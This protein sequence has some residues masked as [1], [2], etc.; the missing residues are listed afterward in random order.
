MTATY[1]FSDRPA[2]VLPRALWGS[3]RS[4][5]R[6]NSFF[7]FFHLGWVALF[8]GGVALVGVSPGP[9]ALWV[10]LAAAF[11][12]PA[13]VRLGW[14]PGPTALWLSLVAAAAAGATALDGDLTRTGW[15]AGGLVF[16]AV[17]A[18][19]VFLTVT[20][21]PLVVLASLESVRKNQEVYYFWVLLLGGVLTLCFCASH[22][23]V[24]YVLF[25]V[26][27]FPMFLLVGQY[28]PRPQRV[29]A[30]YKF[31][32]YTFGGSAFVLP[33]LVYLQFWCGTT[34]V[35]FLA[36]HQFT[37]YEQ[38]VFFGL[39]AVPF[40]V[41]VPL[42]PF[43]LWLPEAHVEAP[44]PVSMLLAG[45]L[46]KTGGYAF[47]RFLLPA[48]P[49]GAYVWGPALCGV[50][51]FSVVF[52][53]AYA[54]VQVDMKRM[55]AYA[56]VAH[57][58]VVFLGVFSG[59]PLGVQGATYLM[60]AHGYTSA[61]LFGGIGV[62]YDRYHTR[63]IRHYGGLA[64][65]MPVFAGLFF[66]LTLGNL[67]FPFTGGFAGEFMILSGV[68]LRNPAV[69]ALAGAT[70][71][72]SLCYSVWLF[73]RLFYGPTARDVRAHQE[74]TPVELGVL[75]WCAFGCV[76]LGFGGSAFVGYTQNCYLGVLYGTVP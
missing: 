17:G 36:A 32:V 7:W 33:V 2:G 34:H 56:S 64:P 28:G 59:V 5:Y 10:P 61:G 14:S 35:A 29:S 16:D 65:L 8:L 63:T 76:A 51:L 25:E 57:M 40:A 45:L 49:A 72:L 31:F 38:V 9:A 71:F 19:Y 4:G 50:G 46:L 60:L 37:E 21:V 66:V 13:G 75:G 54:L 11:V 55:I 62:L 41:K 23:L 70:V 22:F 26:L 3:T 73:N 18:P 39:C 52:A 30:A 1:L 68:A 6:Q 12:Y 44:T 20:L 27:G 58:S 42:V 24:F 67:S 74:A 47:V 69:T 15:A 48:F 53:S 43:H